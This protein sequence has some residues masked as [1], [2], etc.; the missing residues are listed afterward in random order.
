[1][2]GRVRVATSR[3]EAELE[4][5]IDR[6][7]RVLLIPFLSPEE[8]EASLELKTLDRDLVQDGTYF[9]ADDHGVLV[10]CG[11]WGRRREYITGQGAVSSE[12]GLLEPGRDPARVRAMYTH[13]EH[14]RR[15]LGRLILRTC[16][17]AACMV[18]ASSRDLPLPAA[19]LGGT[20]V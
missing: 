9:V 6:S 15:G 12:A 3:D 18:K 16:E 4:R 19:S 1:M 17:N 20:S 10:A 7:T 8:L 5:L 13:P 14:A 11:G 2:T